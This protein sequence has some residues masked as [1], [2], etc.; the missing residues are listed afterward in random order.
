MILQILTI[1]LRRQHG[2]YWLVRVQPGKRKR[3]QLRQA[4]RRCGSRAAHLGA[5][6]TQ[7]HQSVNGS[8]DAGTDGGSS[9]ESGIFSK[10]DT[11]LASFVFTWYGLLISTFSIFSW[12]MSANHLCLMMS[13]EPAFKLPYRF[14]KS[15][16]T[17]FFT[18]AFAL[19]SKYLG[20]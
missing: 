1:P 14:D 12:S 19:R 8:A 7:A 15:A 5:C 20:K 10:F 3:A 6:S 2:T 18:R 11:S 16:V 4:A 13:S 17:S 9:A